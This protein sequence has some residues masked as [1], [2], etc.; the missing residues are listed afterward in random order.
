MDIHVSSLMTILDVAMCIWWKSTSFEMFKKF[1][2]K[3]KIQIRKI[4]NLLQS[5]QYGEYFNQYFKY[6]PKDNKIIS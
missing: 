6:Y 4:I 3:A 5:D 1:R 2:N